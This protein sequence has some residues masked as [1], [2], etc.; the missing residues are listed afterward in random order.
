MGSSWRSLD[1]SSPH[2]PLSQPSQV[3]FK[4][5]LSLLP[6]QWGAEGSREK[7]SWGE[8]KGDR[9]EASQAWAPFVLPSGGLILVSCFVSLFSEVWTCM[10]C[11]LEPCLS[12][13]SLLAWGLCT[14]RWWTRKWTLSPP[15]SPQV[16]HLPLWTRFRTW[17]PTRLAS[18][19]KQC[20]FCCSGVRTPHVRSLLSIKSNTSEW[21]GF[22]SLGS[23]SPHL[24][25]ILSFSIIILNSW[26]PPFS[27][28]LLH[29]THV[30]K[31]SV[32]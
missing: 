31:G 3:C 27:S 18:S 19:V 26:L 30:W 17:A 28:L 13:W 11:W 9:I 8:P 22:P 16:T 2:S 10:P 23:H 20:L 14:R 24:I 21:S 25:L 1:S 15:S 7:A 4:P 5:C 29:R 6:L 12:Q 32:L